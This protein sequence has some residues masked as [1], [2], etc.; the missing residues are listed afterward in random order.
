MGVDDLEAMGSGPEGEGRGIAGLDEVR[1]IIGNEGVWG[2][3][4]R[5]LVFEGRQ[6]AECRRRWRARRARQVW[7]REPAT[8]GAGGGAEPRAEAAEEGA[9]LS[10]GE[11]REVLLAMRWEQVDPLAGGGAEVARNAGAAVAVACWEEGG[12]GEEQGG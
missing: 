9:A 11:G 7:A 1:N 12:A 10:G 3:E 2:R 6:A 5:K 4:G 8:V